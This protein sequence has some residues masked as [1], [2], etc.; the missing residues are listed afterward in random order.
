MPGVEITAKS[1]G[2][3]LCQAYDQSYCQVLTNNCAMPVMDVTARSPYMPGVEVCE[4]LGPTAVQ[5]F[6]GSYY[7][8]LWPTTVV[9]SCCKLHQDPQVNN[10]VMHVV[11]VTA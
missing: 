4:I 3:H 2:Q 5:W 8:I 9:C 1:L 7:K 11:E 10:C 6:G